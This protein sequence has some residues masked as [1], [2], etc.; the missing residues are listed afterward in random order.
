MDRT[1]R[2]VMQRDESGRHLMPWIQIFFFDHEHFHCWQHPLHFTFPSQK[3]MRFLLSNKISNAI[4]L[5]SKH[6]LQSY[7][8]N[9][10]RDAFISLS[11]NLPYRGDSAA[12]F[13][14]H[15]VNRSQLESRNSW[16]L[17]ENQVSRGTNRNLFSLILIQWW[18]RYLIFSFSK[19]F[20]RMIAILYSLQS[21]DCKDSNAVQ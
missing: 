8:R 7:L 12:G 3:K 18:S 5:L 11:N 6:R 1:E 4:T 15:I 16:F 19:S 21:H 17:S 9:I 13:S 20:P 10:K 14:Y 2:E